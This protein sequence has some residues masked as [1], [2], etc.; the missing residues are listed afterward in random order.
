MKPKVESALRYL[1]KGGKKA[2][3]CSIGNVREALKGKA[4]TTITP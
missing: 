3:I 1:A 4:G 2:I